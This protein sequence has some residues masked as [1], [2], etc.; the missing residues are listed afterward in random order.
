MTH[1]ERITP[2]VKLGLRLQYL[3]DVYSN[4]Y[5]LAK[6]N[7][8]I[9][10]AEVV[11]TVAERQTKKN[12]RDERVIFI[13]CPPVTDCISKVNDTQVD[14]TKDVNVVISIYNLLESIDSYSKNLE[15]YGNIF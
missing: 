4:T 15:V 2:I 12:E 10:G 7:I 9:A 11:G 8:A 5:I 3:S 6:A 14:N 13:N 1:V